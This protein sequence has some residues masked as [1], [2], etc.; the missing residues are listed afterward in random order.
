M[1]LVRTV[2]ML[3]IM[4]VIFFISHQ[5]RDMLVLPPIINIDKVAHLIAYGV[6]ASS[7][8][9]AFLPLGDRLTRSRLVLMVICFCILYG[10][11]D[12]FHQSFVPGRQPSIYDVIADGIG[13]L[14]VSLVWLI[15]VRRKEL[16]TST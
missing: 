11:S 15:V 14:I 12:E 13:A 7:M 2:P 3:M 1:S 4:G 10:I 6:L 8:I 16:K 5:S 9:W